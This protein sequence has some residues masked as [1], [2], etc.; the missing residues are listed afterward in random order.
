MQKWKAPKWQ[1]FGNGKN[2][3][4]NKKRIPDNFFDAKKTRTKGSD[5]W[6]YSE[7]H[8]I[9]QKKSQNKKKTQNFEK[10]HQKKIRIL[11]I[12]KESWEF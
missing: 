9:S 6:N 3:K 1:R 8:R 12:F 2:H 10:F 11:R 5:L 4:I 7:F